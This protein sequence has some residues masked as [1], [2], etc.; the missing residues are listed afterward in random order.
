MILACVLICII[1]RHRAQ[2][3]IRYARDLLGKM[4]RKDKGG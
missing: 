4:L 3:G 2:D 1:G